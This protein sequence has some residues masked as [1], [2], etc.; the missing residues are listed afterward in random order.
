MILLATTASGTNYWFDM[1]RKVFTRETYRDT[2]LEGELGKLVERPLVNL[3][4]TRDDRMIITI[5]GQDFPIVTTHVVE[6]DG[7]DEFW[8]S[9]EDEDEE[10][11][12]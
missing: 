4:F 3:E 11:R 10:E 12:R 9:V 1:N 2:T 7:D 6:I 8:D 5:P